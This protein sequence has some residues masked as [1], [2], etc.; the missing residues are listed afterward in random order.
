MDNNASLS[1]AQFTREVI[2][3]LETLGIEYM[4]GG[5][6]AVWAWGEPRAT[7]DLDLVIDLPPEKALVLSQAL[8]DLEIFLPVDIIREYL[9]ETRVDL[10][11]DAIHGSSGYKA[12]MFLLHEGDDLRKTGLPYGNKC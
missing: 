7:Q 8:E 5:A 1:Y 11:I 4:I 9:A 12:E 10:P 6:V 3:M 2:Q